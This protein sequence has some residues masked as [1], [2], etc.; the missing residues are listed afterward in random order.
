MTGWGLL[1]GSRTDVRLPSA[2]VGIEGLQLEESGLTIRHV[3]LNQSHGFH[4]CEV[5]DP[6]GAFS[7][8]LGTIH[9]HPVVSWTKWDYFD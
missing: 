3:C 8:C 1:G 7:L 6:Y 2:G 5:V 4:G 9:C